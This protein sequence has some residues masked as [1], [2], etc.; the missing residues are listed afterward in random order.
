MPADIPCA[1]ANAT[2]IAFMRR[3]ETMPGWSGPKEE[4][5]R[6][7]LDASGLTLLSLYESPTAREIRVARTGK[8]RVGLLPIGMHTLML[9]YD[10]D[11]LTN[12]WSDAPF[13][14]GAQGPGNRTLMARERGQGR[15][16]MSIMA[17]ATSG[18]VHALRG[19][20]LTPSFCDVL[21]D[22]VEAQRAAL[23][24]Y[25]PQAYA[26]ELNAAYARWPTSTAMVPHARIVER[27]GLPIGEA[28]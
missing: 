14:L 10:V 17:D 18:M 16:L 12:S 27:V 25:T 8:M 24:T 3:G 26:A 11:L 9:L 7:I 28:S 20:S 13:A 21:D 22:L 1:E 15:L 5:V 2:A 6:L 4:G 23:P 19:L